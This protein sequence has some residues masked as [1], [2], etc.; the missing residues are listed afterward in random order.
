M[1][2]YKQYNALSDQ[3]SG[4]ATSTLDDIASKNQLDQAVVMADQQE[5]RNPM[6]SDFVVMPKYPTLPSQQSLAQENQAQA[7]AQTCASTTE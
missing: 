5:N 1:A 3:V 4:S 2:L 6:K 7:Q